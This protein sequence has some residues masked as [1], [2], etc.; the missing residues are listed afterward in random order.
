MPGTYE[1]FPI[2]SL[3]SL[4]LTCNWARQKFE[5]FEN[6]FIEAQAGWG[7]LNRECSRNISAIGGG[8]L[9]AYVDIS[10][11]GRT[12]YSEE[13]SRGRVSSANKYNA[14][15][16]SYV[17]MSFDHKYRRLFRCRC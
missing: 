2:L 6:S 9:S 15:N 4:N 5:Q 16:P 10:Q 3:L 8:V 14:E 12:T 13:A 7:V 11:P 1:E 17:S